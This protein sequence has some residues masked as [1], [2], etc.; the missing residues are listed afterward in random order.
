MIIKTVCL[1]AKLNLQE[2]MS[3]IYYRDPRPKHHI[4][5]I[6][7]NAPVSMANLH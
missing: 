5:I 4:A 3:F 1:E 6:V 7:A 2:T